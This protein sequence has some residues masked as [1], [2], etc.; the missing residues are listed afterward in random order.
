LPPVVS[1]AVL[2]GRPWWRRTVLGDRCLVGDVAEANDLMVRIGLRAHL[3]R[4]LQRFFD[5]VLITGVSWLAA[6][7]MY[8]PPDSCLW[9]AGWL[10]RQ[11]RAK[12]ADVHLRSIAYERR[13]GPG[14]PKNVVFEAGVWS[15]PD[16]CGSLGRARSQTGKHDC[17]AGRMLKPASQGAAW[18]PPPSPSTPVADAGATGCTT[19]AGACLTRSTCQPF[20][21]SVIRVWRVLTRTHYEGG[22]DVPVFAVGGLLITILVILAIIALLLFIFGR[23]RI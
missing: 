21:L 6:I 2:S 10:A 1:V 7:P 11:L 19:L 13:P 12:L 18:P 8:L 14:D 23:S 20:A 3:D 22:G 15:T 17:H 4:P 9:D 5:D 16:G